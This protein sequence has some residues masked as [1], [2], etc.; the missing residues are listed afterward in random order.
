MIIMIAIAIA[1]ISIVA[2]VEGRT[3][4]IV[5]IAVIGRVQGV[6]LRFSLSRT[7]L[8]SIGQVAVGRVGVGWKTVA[9]GGMDVAM[10][11]LA[12][13]AI[14]ATIQQCWIGLSFWFG[15]SIGRPLLPSVSEVA[16]V[17]WIGVA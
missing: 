16:A 9:M 12:N 5:W 4:A 6:S 10:N 2:G 7:L 15:L 13:Q 14:I 8:P 1:W 17:G 11:I 3:I